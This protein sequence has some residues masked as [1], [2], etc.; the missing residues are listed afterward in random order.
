MSL[1]LFLTLVRLSGDDITLVEI[2]EHVRTSVSSPSPN[3]KSPNLYSE[4]LIQIWECWA[5]QTAEPTKL[6][7]PKDLGNRNKSEN[8]DGWGGFIFIRSFFAFFWEELARY[9]LWYTKEC[10]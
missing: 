4:G 9:P 10:T 6:H 1:F 3:P 2:R 5:G 7:L 8:L